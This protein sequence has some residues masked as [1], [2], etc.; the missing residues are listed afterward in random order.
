[1][2]PI[3]TVKVNTILAR[4]IATR[5]QKKVSIATIAKKL[6]ITERNY[7]QME[8]GLKSISLDQF[9]HLTAIL[10]VSLINLTKVDRTSDSFA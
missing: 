10:E 6:D 2:K 9:L 1:M 5:Q 7:R 3:Q 4:L 8:S